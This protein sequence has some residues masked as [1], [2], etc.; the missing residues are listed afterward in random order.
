MRKKTCTLARV[1]RQRC[2]CCHSCN[3]H[4]NRNPVSGKITP[5]EVTGSTW[6]SVCVPGA[7][8]RRRRQRRQWAWLRRQQASSNFRLTASLLK[9]PF[10]SAGNATSER[11]LRNVCVM[12]RTAGSGNTSCREEYA[13][14]RCPHSRNVTWS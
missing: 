4:N 14:C 7:C 9:R 11:A 1:C 2:S 8:P 5:A 10:V 13:V 6:G 3:E 12:K